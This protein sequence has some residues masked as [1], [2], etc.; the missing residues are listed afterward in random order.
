MRSS[1]RAVTD[2]VRDK[3]A[4]TVVMLEWTDPIFSMG[5]W[6]PELVE[7]ANGKVL[8]GEKGQHSR[9]IP[10]DRVRGADPDYLIIAPCGYGIERTL[11]EVPLLEALPGWAQLKAVRAGRVALA[12]GNMYFNRSGITIVE[13]VEIIAEILHGHRMAAENHAGAWQ[14]YTASTWKVPQMSVHG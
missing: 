5:N 9:A 8:L 3:P 13:T 7:A 12:D 1:I 4:P 11:R 14:R 10:W 2:A 6:G